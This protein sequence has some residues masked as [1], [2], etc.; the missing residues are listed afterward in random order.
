MSFTV[1]YPKKQRTNDEKLRIRNS[2]PEKL[3]AVNFDYNFKFKVHIK[4]I[5]KK[6]SHLATVTPYKGL[7]KCRLLINAFFK[8][9]FPNAQKLGCDLIDL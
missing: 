5:C 4:N 1:K 7:S 3:L 8:S 9:Q 6:A 2:V